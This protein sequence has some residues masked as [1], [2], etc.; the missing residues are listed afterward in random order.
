MVTHWGVI[1]ALTGEEVTNATLRSLA[2]SRYRPATVTTRARGT[3]HMADARD[4]TG[5]ARRRPPRPTRRA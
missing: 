1:R 2:L 5:T 4:P 3:V